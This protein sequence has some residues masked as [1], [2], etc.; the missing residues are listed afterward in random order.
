M[1]QTAGTARAILPCLPVPDLGKTL[2]KYL[3]SLKPFLLEEATRTGTSYDDL[4]ALKS[5]LVGD[6]ANGLG[7]LCQER[8]H[9]VYFLFL[10]TDLHIYKSF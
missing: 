10:L 4:L 2:S 9:G 3:D 6:F 8:L 5:K 7:N 1:I